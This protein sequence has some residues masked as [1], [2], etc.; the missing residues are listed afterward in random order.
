MQYSNDL[1]CTFKW[2]KY[3]LIKWFKC[4]TQMIWVAHLNGLN[5]NELNDLNAI[6]KWFE[7]HI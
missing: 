6:L 5:T 7:L 3:K 2:F 4:N 1:S